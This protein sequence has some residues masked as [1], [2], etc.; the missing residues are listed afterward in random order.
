MELPTKIFEQI[1]FNARPKIGEHMLIVMEKCNHEEHLAQPRQ[2]YNRQYKITVTF[3]TGQNGIFNV[4]AKNNNFYFTI[5]I[6]DDDF[7]VIT[8]PKG[9]YELEISNDELKRKY[10]QRGPFYRKK[11][12]IC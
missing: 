3:L 4:A 11:L 5:S 6:N 1:A 2:T 12:P 9:A 8:I 10:Y 7:N